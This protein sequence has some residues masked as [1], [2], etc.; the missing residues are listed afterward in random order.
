MCVCLHQ[1]G[2]LRGDH[3]QVIINLDWPWANVVKRKRLLAE[4]SE[5]RHWILTASDLNRTCVWPVPVL[6]N[7]SG[8][9]IY[10]WEIWRGKIIIP[11]S[12]MCF[13]EKNVNKPAFVSSCFNLTGKLDLKKALHFQA[14]DNE[15]LFN[16]WC[17]LKYVNKCAW[18]LIVSL[19]V[20]IFMTPAQPAE[21]I[22]WKKGQLLWWS[23]IT[24]PLRLKC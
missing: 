9:W 3:W 19:N 12:E 24:P 16:R 15:G 17:W 22:N 7:S 4:V 20:L 18:R 8:S 2:L 11:N 1:T 5:G 13:P 6:W 23:D 10:L 21:E 14:D